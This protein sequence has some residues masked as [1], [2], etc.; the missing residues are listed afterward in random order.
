MTSNLLQ[1]RPPKKGRHSGHSQ[2]STLKGRNIG[3]KQSRLTSKGLFFV[4]IVSFGLAPI[5]RTVRKG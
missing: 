4:S 1:S 3:T 5:S 2:L